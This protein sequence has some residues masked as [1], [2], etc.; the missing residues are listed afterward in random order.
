MCDFCFYLLCFLKKGV[1]FII[2]K[3]IFQ[4]WT[5]LPFMLTFGSPL[6][7]LHVDKCWSDLSPTQNTVHNTTTVVCTRQ[8]FNLSGRGAFSSVIAQMMGRPSIYLLFFPLAY[9]H[10]FYLEAFWVHS[11][12]YDRFLSFFPFELLC[13]ILDFSNLA[14]LWH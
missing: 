8:G 6:V 3:C 4:F 12:I 1:F 7:T 2:L 14:L 10:T 11:S 9:S 13:I 5:T